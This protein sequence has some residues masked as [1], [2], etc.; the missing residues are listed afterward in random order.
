[1]F[2]Y[3]KDGSSGKKKNETEISDDNG[4]YTNVQEPINQVGIV[5]ATNGQL[6]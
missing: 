3:Q 2:W 5:R 6:Y 4:A 1:L